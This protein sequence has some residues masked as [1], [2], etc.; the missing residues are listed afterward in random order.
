[1]ETK[2]TKIKTWISSSFQVITLGLLVFSV[3][4][5]LKQQNDIH[6]LQGKIDDVYYQVDQSN[7][8]INNVSSKLDD[9]ESRLIN[10]IE[11]VKSTIRLWSN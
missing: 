2:F 10:E 7:D 11:D 6:K 3:V 4:I 5:V 9:V 8:N 1:M